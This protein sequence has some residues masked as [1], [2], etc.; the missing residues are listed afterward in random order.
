MEQALNVVYFPE[1]RATPR[2]FVSIME[3]RTAI[4]AWEQGHRGQV[5]SSTSPLSP[6]VRKASHPTPSNSPCSSQ[7]STPLLVSMSCSIL[8][9]VAQRRKEDCLVIRQQVL[10]L[11]TH[12]FSW[13]GTAWPLFVY[14]DPCGIIKNRWSTRRNEDN[15]RG[16]CE[17]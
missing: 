10:S 16:C 11:T 5:S 6:V 7:R 4:L 2:D 14:S 1:T 15:H 13:L 9:S 12:V 17:K 8:P 3:L